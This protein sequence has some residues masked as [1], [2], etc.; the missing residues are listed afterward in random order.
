LRISKSILLLVVAAMAVAFAGCKHDGGEGKANNNNATGQ[1]GL[2]LERAEEVGSLLFAADR[3][4][5]VYIGGKELIAG[6]EKREAV[7]VCTGI[8]ATI[9]LSRDRPNGIR[10]MVYIG[11]YGYNLMNDIYSIDDAYS[12]VIDQDCDALPDVFY[13]ISCY[14]FD[15]DGRDEIVLACGDKRSQ[16][17]LYV[18][19]MDYFAGS[20]NAQAPQ[21]IAALKGDSA[22]YVN[23]SG[24]LCIPQSNG[25]LNMYR[26]AG[27]GFEAVTD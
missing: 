21:L 12:S 24:W 13:E 25:G 10:A 27:N 14:D 18:F 2:R 26:Y 19:T 9:L 5:C 15:H 6:A 20:Y 8:E 1:E 17:K 23:D 4:Y 22:A 3:G 16:L 11:P 7:E